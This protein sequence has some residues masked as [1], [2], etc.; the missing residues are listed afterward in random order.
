MA[1]GMKS[2]EKSPSKAWYVLPILLAIIGGLIIYFV[3]RSKDP[4]MAR[5]GLLLGILVFM[6]SIVISAATIYF[7]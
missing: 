4:R 3:L 5:N 6:V 7:G 1:S 2:D